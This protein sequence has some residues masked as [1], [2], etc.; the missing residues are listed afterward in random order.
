VSRQTG[1]VRLEH[2]FGSVAG[3]EGAFA[4]DP[5][6]VSSDALRRAIAACT[7]LCAAVEG[8]DVAPAINQPVAAKVLRGPLELCQRELAAIGAIPPRDQVRQ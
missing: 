1:A 6:S 5:R 8:L 2:R 4:Y 3:P 7:V